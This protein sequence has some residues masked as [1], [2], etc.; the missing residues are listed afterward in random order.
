[1]TA[2]QIIDEIKRITPEER[3]QVSLFLMQFDVALFSKMK[4]SMEAHSFH[5]ADDSVVEEASERILNRHASLLK[6]LA[7]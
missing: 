2:T 4:N 1:M 3:E 5:H 6:K 7:S